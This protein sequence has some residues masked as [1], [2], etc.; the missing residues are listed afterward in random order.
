[1][2]LQFAS[3][4]I[5]DPQNYN[6][7]Q[8][9]P[10]RTGCYDLKKCDVQMGIDEANEEKGDITIPGQGIVHSVLTYCRKC[11]FSCPVGKPVL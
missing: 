8:K 1:M 7:L 6:G 10:G 9:L 3:E 11:E 2:R 4:I 5:Y